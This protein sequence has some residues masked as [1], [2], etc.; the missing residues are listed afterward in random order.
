MAHILHISNF[1]FIAGKLGYSIGG[2]LRQEI[3]RKIR[4]KTKGNV[5]LIVTGDLFDCA[6]RNYRKAEAFIRDISRDMGLD[7]AQDVFLVPGDQDVGDYDTLRPLLVSEDFNWKKHTTAALEM[8]KKGEMEYVDERIQVFRAYSNLVR[9]L[10]IYSTNEGKD[11]PASTHVRCW[12]GKLNIL[13]LNTAL[14]AHEETKVEQMADVVT[15]ANPD[16]W[17]KHYND[18]IP[19]LAI[20]HNS[21]YDLEEKQRM[22]L[23]TVFNLRNVRAYLCDKP[24]LS[25]IT[26][27]K[28]IIRLESGQRPG[29]EIPNLA[30][31][32]GLVDEEEVDA[33]VGFCWYSWDEDTG[34]VDAEYKRCDS[35][36]IDRA[37][38]NGDVGFFSMNDNCNK[39]TI[40]SPN[41][42]ANDLFQ[43]LK[44]VLVQIRDN[45]PSFVLMRADEIDYRLFPQARNNASVTRKNGYNN[46]FITEFIP[47]GATSFPKQ[48]SPVW[49]IIKQ[50]WNEPV[51]RNIVISGEGGIGKTVTLF[52]ICQSIDHVCSVPAIYIPMYDLIYGGKYKNI[53]EYILNHYQYGADILNLSA[54]SWQDHPKLL[55]LLDGF[56][57]VPDEYRWDALSMVNDWYNFYPGVQIV[58]VSRPMDGLNLAEE[59]SGNPIEITLLKLDE[60]TIRQLLNEA[61]RKV[62]PRGDPVW[63][64]L[65]YP[66]FLNLYIKTRRLKNKTSA[67]YPLFV[68]DSESG[69]VLI[70][71]YLQ[72]ELLQH[73]NEDWL[74]RCVFSCEY[75]LPYVAY[76]MASKH[77]MTIS[78]ADVTRLVMQAIKEFD[79]IALPEHLQEI[80][81]KYRRK[82]HNELFLLTSLNYSKWYDSVTRDFGILVPTSMSESSNSGSEESYSFVHQTFR[83]CLAGLHLVNQAETRTRGI[84]SDV[85]M[86]SNN[87]ITLD[88]VAELINSK[89]AAKLWK[90]NQKLRPT[91]SIATYNVLELQKRLEPSQRCNLDFSGMDLRGIDLTNYCG[92]NEM[93]LKLFREATQSKGTKIDA[94]TFQSQSHTKRITSIVDAGNGLCISASE[95]GTIRVWDINTAQC[96]QRINVNRTPI[97]CV[98]ISYGICAFGADD[99]TVRLWDYKT[100]KIRKLTTHKQP[101]TCVK[102]TPEGMCVSGSYEGTIKA[103]SIAEHKPESLLRE[104]KRPITCLDITKDGKCIS[105]STDRTLHAWEMNSG[106]DYSFGRVHLNKITAI[107]IVALGKNEF[108]FVGELDG[109]I[110]AYDVTTNILLYTIKLHS[111]EIVSIAKT[112]NGLCFS[113][114]YDGTMALW[115]PKTGKLVM[116]QKCNKR[117]VTSAGITNYGTIIVGMVDGSMQFWD[118]DLSR[119]MQAVTGRGNS[120]SSIHFWNDSNCII[121]SKTCLAQIWNTQSGQCVKNLRGHQD[122]VTAIAMTSEHTCITGSQDGKIIIWNLQTGEAR[123]EYNGHNHPITC[124]SVAPNNICVSASDDGAIQVWKIDTNELLVDGKLAEPATNIAINS[125]GLCIVATGA[126]R[127]IIFDYNNG[128]VYGKLEGSKSLISRVAFCYDSVCAC[129][130]LFGDIEIQDVGSGELLCR[131]RTDGRRIIYIDS[132]G[133]YAT[134]FDNDTV[135]VY[136]YIGSSIMGNSI[137]VQLAGQLGKVNCIDLFKNKY[138]AT[139]SDDG[140]LR[141][142]DLQTGNCMREIATMDVDVSLMNFTYAKLDNSLKY[143]LKDNG[144]AT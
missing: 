14:I 136:N 131:I 130:P 17:N 51:K 127:P 98:D 12:R 69:G 105:G 21:F 74:L 82:H 83:D 70:W 32:N 92:Q 75:L 72:R 60:K 57:E 134:D 65:R 11:Y 137:S 42:P 100:N 139:G 23:A 103:K 54:E 8:V 62:P 121:G 45:H 102:L 124:I 55:V 95:D 48:V 67:G 119:E 141:I 27:E 1:H 44:N 122:V 10:G 111:D 126:S 2:I 20:G 99:R 5:L 79:P 85:W 46:Q 3:A 101:V 35:S 50:S 81:N 112:P 133:Y 24:Y 68:R 123:S 25:A 110:T 144:A 132:D 58:A 129:A 97:N 80:Q 18:A 104:N 138:C 117:A 34:N 115:N 71:N 91:N 78:Y 106:E 53:S 9:R 107:K 94:S 93:A 4:D 49:E 76:D 29:K 73:K 30:A 56:N 128:R 114:S 77:R 7:L 52:S 142:W 16:T 66:L 31:A 59:M 40:K 118:S 43:Y 37:R 36:C 135:N 84:C 86:K 140:K 125:S 33:G 120:I 87:P 109:S 19:T 63:E 6:E 38:S 113:V 96:V 47:D 22:S 41:Y 116:E 28:Q 61:K 26:P 88:Y 108:C 89:I 13:H 143:L 90:D 39:E 64:V 15:A